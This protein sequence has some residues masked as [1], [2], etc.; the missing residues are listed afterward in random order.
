MFVRSDARGQG[1]S[2]RNV[3]PIERDVFVSDLET[4]IESLGLELFDLVSFYG[5]AMT[6]IVYA[7]RHPAR[8]RRMVLWSPVADNRSFGEGQLRTVMS[9][10]ESDWKLFTETFA[11][12]FLGW[13][14]DVA[15]EWA[16]FMRG[17]MNQEDAANLFASIVKSD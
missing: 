9:L 2:Q 12:V 7:V 14:G 16:S 6:H 5:P 15:H 8:V 4:V 1:L 3:G 13:T 10:I 11:R 17:S